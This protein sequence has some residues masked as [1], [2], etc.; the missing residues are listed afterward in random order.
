MAFAFILD[1]VGAGEWFI[2]LAVL[3]VVMGPKR[4]PATARTIGSYYSKFRRAAET[5][6]RQLMDMD[7][8]MERELE[9]A[10]REAEEALRV[11]ELEEGPMQPS[12][13]EMAD[14]YAMPEASD[15]AEAAADA[16]A[17][18]LAEAE[19][20]ADDVAHT[21]TQGEVENDVDRST[22]ES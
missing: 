18:M 19:A 5:F 17:E 15:E 14:P 6:K 16:H 9:R 1:S 20:I 7:W 22:E 11:P 10:K 4:L 13:T 8:E 2:L 12:A 3:L 21:Q